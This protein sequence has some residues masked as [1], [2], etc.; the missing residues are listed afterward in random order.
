MNDVDTYSNRSEMI[1]RLETGERGSAK[2]TGLGVERAP[3][4]RV[5]TGEHANDVRQTPPRTRRRHHSTCRRHQ[6]HRRSPTTTREG[7]KGVERCQVCSLRYRSSAV[8]KRMSE[9]AVSN[10]DCREKLESRA[11]NQ[12]GL[13]SSPSHSRD[14]AIDTDLAEWELDNLELSINGSQKEDLGIE[15]RG[16]RDDPVLGTTVPIYIK[17]VTKG[18]KLDGQLRYE[19]NEIEGKK[20][21]QMGMCLVHMIA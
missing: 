16:G 13:A 10:F 6:R 18:S 5:G 12:D 21:F 20:P 7:R 19:R 15:L 2:Q 4:D 9:E 1:C 14:S 17:S 8:R 3:K 11:T